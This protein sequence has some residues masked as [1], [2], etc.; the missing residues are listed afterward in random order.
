[1]T[2][3][4]RSWLVTVAA[5]A[6]GR[7]VCPSK[8][9]HLG[10]DGGAVRVA[11]DIG[12]NLGGRVVAR[13]RIAHDVPLRSDGDIDRAVDVL[14]VVDDQPAGVDDVVVTIGAREL[15]HPAAAHQRLVTVGLH[16]QRF[17]RFAVVAEVTGRRSRVG[18]LDGRVG[19]A[20]ARVRVAVEA[21]A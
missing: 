6:A 7:A 18:P 20:A 5:V 3:C 12:A 2:I 21:R 16:L 17:A 8:V 10:I 1:M 9:P 19:R 11:V 4:A 15:P 13:R 14:A